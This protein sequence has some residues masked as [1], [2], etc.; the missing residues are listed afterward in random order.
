MKKRREGVDLER[1]VE[2]LDLGVEL[3]V[4]VRRVQQPPPL[5]H[6]PSH[7]RLWTTSLHHTTGYGP[8]PEK[9]ETYRGSSLIRKRTP[10][11]PHRRPMPRVVGGSDEG[12]RFLMGEVRLYVLRERVSTQKASLRGRL[13]RLGVVNSR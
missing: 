2:V 1:E 7:H 9:A 4:D 3:G 8:Q 12:G 11:G 10:L 6:T 13:T 5:L